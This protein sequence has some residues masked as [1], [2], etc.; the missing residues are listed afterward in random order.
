MASL[1]Q[2]RRNLAR[3]FTEPAARALAATPLSPNFLTWSGFVVTLAAA[4][5]V[6]ARFFII[7]GIVYIV[8]ALFDMLDGALA[9]ATGK[10]TRFGAVLDSSLDRVSEGAVLIG[11]IVMFA[12]TGFHWEAMLCGM[13][14]LF[15][16]MVSYIRAR[17]EGM[18]VE[19]KAGFFTRPERVILM[20]VALLVG[21]NHVALVAIL[22]V[23]TVL[24]LASAIQRLAYAR[25]HAKEAD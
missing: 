3:H 11:L 5:L 6:A 21:Y 20:T 24:S 18:G 10:A 12:R 15:S 23:I 25:R 9:R 8:A 13:T 14:M 4:F 17:M 22:I 19:C 1:E 16:F 2:A 7:A